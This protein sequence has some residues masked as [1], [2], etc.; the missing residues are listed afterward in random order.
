MRSGAISTEEYLLGKRIKS[1]NN[2]DVKKS[3][4]LKSKWLQNFKFVFFFVASG[5]SSAPVD[6]ELIDKRS[7]LDM[8]AKMR[9]DPIYLMKYEYINIIF[10]KH[11]LG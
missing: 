7:Q 4:F 3:N 1:L 8:H 10:K 6:K 9:E 2:E 5:V 11:F